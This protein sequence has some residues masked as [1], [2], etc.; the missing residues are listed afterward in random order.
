[1][2]ITDLKEAQKALDEFRARFKDLADAASDWLWEMDE[3][4]RFTYVTDGVSRF[5]GGLEPNIYYGKTR[6]EVGIPDRIDPDKWDRHLADLEA[7]RPF[8]NFR[9][10]NIDP[11]GDVHYWSISGRPVF[12]ATG[13]FLGYRGLGRD[14]TARVRTEEKLRQLNAELQSEIIE[15][16]QA[17]EALKQARNELEQRVEE[18]TRDLHASEKRF[19]DF[20]EAAADWFWEMDA[21]LRFTYMS[22]NVEWLAGVAP[23]WHYGK[24]RTEI[25]GDDYNRD[26]WADHL[27]ALQERKPFR[28]FEY[29]RDGEGVEPKWLRA[30]GLPVFDDD[31]AFIGYRG[32][33]SDITEQKLAEER[34]RTSEEKLVRAQKMEAV[35]QLT[36][37]VAHDFNNLLAVISG[38]SEFLHDEIG[39]HPLLDTINRATKRGAE[40]TQRL[41]AFSRQQALQ[42]QSIDLKELIPV[43]HD[44]LD[45]TLG[46]PIEILT[47]VAQGSWPV[48]ADPGQLE[49]ALLNLA[50]NA[51]DAM[52][53]GGVLEIVCSNVE[54]HEGDHR[55]SDEVAAG[56][57]VQITVRDTGTGMSEEV[58]E[59]VF[60][61]FYTTKDVGEGSGL[62]L[63]M[64]YGFARQSGGDAVI[65]S[66]PGT[67]TQVKILLPRA[68]A[69][70]ASRERTQFSN[71]KRGRGESVLVLED[72]PD[73]RA[74]T[75]ASLEGLGYQVREAEDANAA[76]LI[77]EEQANNPDL[78]LSDMVLPGGISGPELAAR[79][80][81]LY[82]KMKI[83]FMTGYA[84][85]L[86]ATDKAPE[87][88]EA[89]LT[90][91]FKRADLATVIYDTLA[92]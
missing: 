56:D 46:E 42:P 8:R 14:I 72:D 75:V 80:K 13:A 65:E 58:L 30:S 31:G 47:D 62:G 53:T 89:L 3:E 66:E 67:G 73:V 15:R 5:N 69:D 55:V 63:S 50:I 59:H 54:L 22:E 43:V 40:L 16:R 44:L 51:R 10:T 90:K 27:K 34:L 33:G 86:Y 25:L 23:E 61:P 24:T 2:P 21:D 77:L 82:P 32:T 28:N 68:E 41:L 79:A 64:V 6:E 9:Y 88:G 57:Y 18:R 48:I 83:V 4:L 11:A 76:M 1:M 37:G 29:Y 45:R 60:E 52:A 92:T 91:P 19:R 85:D 35:G 20:A 36:G 12:D 39:D 87:I 70:V 84:S 74:L 78:L 81:D 49:N 26:I 17:E 71:L 38:T 7:R